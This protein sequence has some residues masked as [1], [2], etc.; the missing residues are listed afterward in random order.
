MGTKFIKI[1]TYNVKIF[2]RK[3]TK[4]FFLFFLSVSCLFSRN[5]IWPWPC[6]KAAVFFVDKTLFITYYR[7]YER[8]LV[9]SLVALG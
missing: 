5:G 9:G 3:I 2:L 8:N 4:K 1:F 6:L 7:L